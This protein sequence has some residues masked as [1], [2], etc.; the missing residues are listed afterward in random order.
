MGGFNQLR[1]YDFRNFIGNS[2]AFTNLEFRYPLVDEL[3]FPF[4][5]IR[6]IRGTILLDAGAAWFEDDLWYDPELGNFRFRNELN[7]VTGKSDI[8]FEKFKLF[9][10]DGNRLQDL[11]ASWGVGF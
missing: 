11:R 7:P 8:V 5:G 2:I 10:D 9:D 4:G 6:Q 3:A 1:G